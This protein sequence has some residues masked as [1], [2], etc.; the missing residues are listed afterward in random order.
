METGGRYSITRQRIQPRKQLLSLV[1]DVVMKNGG[2][3]CT[4]ELFVEF[5]KG[6]KKLHD[7]AMVLNSSE[8]YSKE[9]KSEMEE[10]MHKSHEE[11]L[12]RITDMETS[13]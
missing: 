11:H 3:P 7:Q 1:N 4:D 8:G 6:A 5:K 9:K 12:T 13:I 10:R 2:K